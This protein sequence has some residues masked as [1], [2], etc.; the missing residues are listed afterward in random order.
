MNATAMYESAWDEPYEP[1]E[2]DIEYTVE[3]AI[4]DRMERDFDSFDRWADRF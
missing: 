1:T 2:D 4:E 3:R